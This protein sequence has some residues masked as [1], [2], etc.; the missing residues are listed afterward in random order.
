M[1][2]R[3]AEETTQAKSIF[4]ANMSHEIRTPM[5]AIIGMAH[6][7]LLTDLNVKQRDYVEKI[8]G[9]G[10]SLLGIIN[11]ILDFSKIEAGKLNMEAVEFNL[12]DVLNNVSTLTSAKAHE[13]GLEYLIQMAP[14]IP[15]DLVGDPLR[16]GQ[17]LINLINNAVKFT[18][19]GEIVIACRALGTTSDRHIELE[20]SVRDTGIGM[21]EAQSEKLFRAFSQADE[22]TTRKYGGTGLGLSISKGMVELMGGTISLQSEVNRGTTIRFTARF[23]LIEKENS[24]L[25]IPS[26][27]N[28]LRILIVDDNAAARQVM[29]EALS[30]LPVTVDQAASGRTALAA[31]H[32]QDKENPYGVI[33]TDLVMPEMDGIELIN[34]IKRDAAIRHPPRTILVSAYGRDEVLYG[35]DSAQADGFLMKPVS[36]S[37]IIDVLVELYAPESDVIPA[38]LTRTETRFSGLTILLVEDNEINQQIARELLE[39]VGI[40]VDI[41]GNG[42]IAVDMLIAG[43]PQRYGMVFMDVQM[44]EMDGHA[45]TRA[46][47]ARADFQKLPIIA[48]TAHAMVEERERCLAAGMNDHLSKPVNPEELYAAVRTWC[49]SHIDDTVVEKVTL[50]PPRAAA[51]APDELRIPGIDV[52]DGLK[53]TLGNR[54]FYLQMLRR[55]H[56]D[57]ANT[58][59]RI[60]QA[61]TAE[62]DRPA[63]ERLV[64]TLK[65]VAG[66]LGVTVVSELALEAE[67]KIRHGESSQALMPILSCLETELQKVRRALLPVLSIAAEPEQPTTTPGAAVDRDA[68]H[69]LISRIATLLRQYDGDAIELLSE[70]NALLASALGSMAH[71]KISRAARKFDFDAALDALIEGAGTAGYEI[72]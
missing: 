56:D 23:G 25:V 37:M 59:T 42:R 47:R 1:A 49:P 6:L 66:Q 31:I 10:I 30:I 38:H 29:L 40:K 15:R 35:V 16:L 27:I 28:D 72:L 8:H 43:G 52:S 12:D 63:A 2:R 33:F 69:Q 54:E 57:Q 44:P 34:T 67:T 71:Q 32:A 60:I 46:I 9:A 5:N 26:A 7:A 48:M 50:P 21:S 14:T 20:F 45:A 3:H 39:S 4:L 65:G 36:P 41:A 70:S 24:R 11:D 18:E 55:F 53:R 22:S 58:V 51:S 68:A 19:T 17:V 64:H 61:L 62:Q 13:K